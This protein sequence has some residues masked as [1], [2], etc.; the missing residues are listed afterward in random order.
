VLPR[1]NDWP[2]YL[3]VGGYC[4]L[5]EELRDRLGEI[6]VDRELEKWL[7]AGEPPIFFGFGSMPVADPEAL[8]RLVHEACS[9]VGARALVASGWTQFPRTRTPEVMVIDPI[10]HDAL[11]PR[12]RA[13]V[14]HGGAG[15]T[16][17]SL[18][19]GIPTVVCSLFADQPLW[20]F[21]VTALGAG[22]TLPFQRLSLE[23]LGQALRSAL[24]DNVGERA[25]ALGAALR[26]R[27]GR[28]H[29]AELLLDAIAGQGAARLR[30]EA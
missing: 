5:Q 8:L 2:S 28:A 23:T 19:A 14:H 11:L 16:A 21:R 26:A 9:G 25:R 30:G 6:G 29:S 27:S 3:S 17:A 22:V 24:R 13:A 7:N 1:P 10:N 4:D 18:A 15:T 12:C 20:G